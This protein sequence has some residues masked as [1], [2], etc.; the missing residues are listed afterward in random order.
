M[1]ATTAADAGPRPPI[2]KTTLL[3]RYN[4][5]RDKRLRA[6]SDGNAQCLPLKGRFAHYLDDPYT[7][8]AQR[9]P[10]AGESDLI[11]SRRP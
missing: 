8:F 11:Q 6:D 1:T 4:A 5:E 9:E 10:K 2:G 3:A 7:P